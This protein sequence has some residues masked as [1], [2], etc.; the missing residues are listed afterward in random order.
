VV[1]VE[2]E[3]RAARGLARAADRLAV[4]DARAISDGLRAMGAQ[5]I[6]ALNKIDR[7]KRERLLALAEALFDEALHTEV[8]MISASGG[9]GVADLKGALARRMPEGPW[10]YPPD[11]SA[12]LPTRL[13]AAEI[14]REKLYQRVHEEL[15]YSAAVETTAFTDQ[16]DGSARIEQTILVERDGQRGIIIGHAGQTLKWI[17][18]AAREELVA[19]LDR[20]VHLML[21]VKVRPGWSEDRRLFGDVGLDFDV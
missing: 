13:L 18:Q 20:P 9:A 4:R 19:L 15:P 1:D 21:Q 16:A 14:T 8:F 7:L 12:D 17:G 2:A 10:L 3:E 11:Q 6:L 5:A